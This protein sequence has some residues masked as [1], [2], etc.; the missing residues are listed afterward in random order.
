MRMI[1]SLFSRGGILAAGLLW[2][3]GLLATPTMA[4]SVTYNFTGD[5][6][7]VDSLV[8]SKFNN[9]MTMSG[10]MTVDNVDQF[11]GSG[12]AGIY[13]VQSFTVSI[14]GY[15]ATL[16]PS[17][18]SSTIVF[19][20]PTGDGFF[21]LIEQINGE[22]VNFLGPRNFTMGLFG[23]STIWDSDA[24]P[25]SVPSLS[26]FASVNEFRLGFGPVGVNAG[27]SGVLTSLTAVPLPAAVILFGAGL[28]SLVGLGAGGL[29]NLHG[30]KV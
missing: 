20:A 22:N 16:G 23:P 27:V 10:S 13:A 29:R 12:A 1:R 28:I 7:G 8:S 9:S 25:T 24:L 4:A 30:S 2:C 11:P 26:S 6:T 18:D 15:T 14:G 21:S 17:A 3:S 5:V 19:N